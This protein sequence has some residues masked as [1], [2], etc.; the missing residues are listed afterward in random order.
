MFYFFYNEIFFRMRTIHDI[1]DKPIPIEL[2]GQEVIKMVSN[3]FILTRAKQ[4]YERA[5]QS[6]VKVEIEQV[7]KSN[8][9]IK[10]TYD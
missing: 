4:L 9:C 10:C 2:I 5:S 1:D 6:L 3:R 7:R 8:Y